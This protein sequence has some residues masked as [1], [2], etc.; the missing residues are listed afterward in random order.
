MDE[1][2]IPVRFAGFVGGTGKGVV[3]AGD[4]DRFVAFVALLPLKQDFDNMEA[5]KNYF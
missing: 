1:N 3:F 5:L 4:K 2:D